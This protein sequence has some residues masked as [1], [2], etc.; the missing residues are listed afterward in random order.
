MK[1]NMYLD[2]SL[3]KQNLLI[4]LLHREQSDFLLTLI[5]TLLLVL[6]LISVFVDACTFDDV[7]DFSDSTFDHIYTAI[8]C[9]HHML[10]FPPFSARNIQHNIIFRTTNVYVNHGVY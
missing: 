2:T 7:T 9:P 10:T 5:T 8:A 3:S 4:Q 6:P 1:T